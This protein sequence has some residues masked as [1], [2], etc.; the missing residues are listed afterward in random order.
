MGYKVAVV[1]FCFNLIGSLYFNVVWI[2]LYAILVKIYLS[3]AVRA[4]YVGN[5]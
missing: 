3:V 2:F 1:C 5:I 4:V